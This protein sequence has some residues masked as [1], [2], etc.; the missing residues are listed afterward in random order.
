MKKDPASEIK[1]IL[2]AEG[3]NP[4][5]VGDCNRTALWKILTG[6]VSPTWRTIQKLAGALGYTAYV[7]FKGEAMEKWSKNPHPVKWC[8][9]CGSRD[10]G[11]LPQTDFPWCKSCR[12]TFDVHY[13][14]TIRK[15]P[16]KK[17]GKDG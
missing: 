15:S 5:D 11:T 17:N 9:Y 16:K 7:I 6:R 12:R 2:A 1:R 4:G 10:L 8:P 14:R 3:L 13:W